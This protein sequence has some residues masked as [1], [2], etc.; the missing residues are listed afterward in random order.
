MSLSRK[1]VLDAVNHRQPDRLPVDFGAMISTGMHCSIIEALR[2]R[3]GLAPGPVKVFDTFQM[4][5]T[6]DDDLNEAMGLDTAMILPVSTQYGNRLGEW[7][8]WRAIWGQDILI[9]KGMEVE[10][11]PDGSAVA[12]PQGD[13]AAGP[14]ARMP[15]SGFFFDAIERQGEY[16]EENPDPHDNADEDFAV[17]SDADLATLAENAAR[18]RRTGKATMITLPGGTLS[19]PAGLAGMAIKKPRGMRRLVDWYMAL[20]TLPDFVTGILEL[21]TEVAIKNLE[22]INRAAGRDIDLIMVCTADF[23]TQQAPLIAKRTLDDLF[24][25]YYKKM[26]GWIHRNTAWKTF[27][28]CCG[29]IEPLIGSLVEAGFDILNPVQCAAA[30]MDPTHL[31]RTYGDRIAFWGGGVDTQ[32][33]MPFGTP[34][35]VR[36][37]VVERCRIFSEGG[38][39]VFNA[40]HNIQALTP[41]DNVIAMLD[42]VKEFHAAGG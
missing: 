21:Q 26:T 30:G 25:P 34:A 5:G 20:A 36:K 13:R 3:L 35:E 9:P 37:Q 15:A 2:K 40:V 7:K 19:S 16:D 41:I 39:Y 18:A 42:G 6:I 22:R 28:H 24:L 11:L 27:K 31:K 29:A 33:V 8:E 17:L 10:T 12:F 14:S 1:R 32:S 23:G 38:G 4:L